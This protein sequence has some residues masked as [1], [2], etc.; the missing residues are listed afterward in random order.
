MR[1]FIYLILS[2]FFTSAAFAQQNQDEQRDYRQWAFT[3]SIANTTLDSEQAAREGIDDTALA[4]L[5]ALDYRNKRTIFG[6]GVR[7]LTYDD[8][9]SFRQD[10]TGGEMSSS[11]SAFTLF[12]EAGYRFPLH[13][14]VS[15]DI[16]AGI[17]FILESERSI[18]NCTDCFS[19]D[20]DI[21]SGPYLSPRLAF[22]LNEN[23]LL[24][25]TYE[26]Y[27]SGDL[28]NNVSA[29]IGYKF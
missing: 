2:I 6:G 12:G 9:A 28:E 29:S 7:L 3:F 13:K 26:Q 22:K 10:T 25:V 4:F 18:D 1:I 21:E 19:D 17:E 20:I 15:F 11:A 14:H 5:F 23:W 8:N 16:V 27:F 24:G